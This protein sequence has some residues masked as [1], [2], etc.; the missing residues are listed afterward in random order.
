MTHLASHLNPPAKLQPRIERPRAPGAKAFLDH[1]QRTFWSA[2]D[3][4]ACFDQF[5]YALHELK[6]RC[7]DAW[8]RDFCAGPCREHPL[9]DL[10]EEDPFTRRALEKPRGYPSD[11]VMLDFIYSGL[12]AVESRS[13]TERGKVIF[14]RSA[15]Q[16]PS[17]KSVVER[18]Q[19]LARYIDET[20]ERAP[21][22]RILS[23]AC[24]H[25]REARDSAA[26]HSGMLGELVG[27]DQDLASLEIVARELAGLAVTPLALSVRDVIAKRASLSGFDLVY[28]AGLYDYLND[29]AAAQL[30]RALFEALNPGG[31]L[32]IA[33][34]VPGFATHAHMEAFMGW[35]LTCRSERALT[36][37]ASSLDPEAVLAR[38]SF[39]DRRGYIAYLEITRA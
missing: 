18:K 14:E 25:L 20:S 16:S 35:H 39:V 33:N 2:R 23:M 30:T 34:F 12:S 26:A 8:W 3:L 17:A 6:K 21:R 32:L 10:L 4:G 38:K 1:A 15:R 31:R 7:G 24:G 36:A 28:S 13:T 5:T 37:L 11:A 9:R 29:N 27:C 19:L 22:A